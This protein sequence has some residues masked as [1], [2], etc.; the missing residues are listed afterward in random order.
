MNRAAPQ[1]ADRRVRARHRSLTVAALFTLAAHGYDHSLPA[2][3]SIPSS[4]S[5]ASC[6]IFGQMVAKSPFWLATAFSTRLMSRTPLSR[7]RSGGRTAGLGLMGEEARLGQGDDLGD[8][9]AAVDREDDRDA[10]AE[11]GVRRQRVV[12]DQLREP[13]S[14]PGRPLGS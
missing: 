7:L 2:F 5:A 8:Q 14:G 11:G 10:P 1:G 13:G 12:D 9:R 3:W 6:T 4:T